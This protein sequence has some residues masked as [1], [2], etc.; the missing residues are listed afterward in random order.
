MGDLKWYLE[1]L[2]FRQVSNTKYYL[3]PSICILDVVEAIKRHRTLIDAHNEKEEKKKKKNKKERV[4][5]CMPP[6]KRRKLNDESTDTSPLEFSVPDPEPYRFDEEPMHTP[7][8][9]EDKNNNNDEE[10]QAVA[11]MQNGL[12]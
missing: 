9:N 12:E 7:Q 10:L 5:D 6:T 1:Q 2:W 3:I 11:S 8:V 4:M